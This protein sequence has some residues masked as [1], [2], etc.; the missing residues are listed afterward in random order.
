MAGAGRTS[1]K[2]EGTS[3]DNLPTAKPSS[4]R[5]RTWRNTPTTADWLIGGS[6]QAL[7]NPVAV[8]VGVDGHVYVLDFGA[9]QVLEFS[10]TQE[11]IQSYGKGRGAGPG[12]MQNPTDFA[13][14][15]DR[16]VWVLDPG[17]G[18]I[19]VFAPSGDPVNSLHT[20]VSASRIVM[21]PDGGFILH[22]LGESLFAAYTADGV[23]SK[24]L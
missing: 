22:T 18:R 7:L 2:V 9:L 12:E 1:A 15:P 23:H 20:D 6:G 19:T 13:V 16:S 4:A 21:Y 8:R 17:L 5:M 24:R 10:P 3:T 14:A 11:L